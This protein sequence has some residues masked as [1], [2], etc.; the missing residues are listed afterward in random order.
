[1]ETAILQTQIQQPYRR[2]SWVALLQQIFDRVEIFQQPKSWPL[3]TQSEKKLARDLVQ[4]GRVT[5]TDGKLI[6]LFEVDVSKDVDLASNRVGLRKL[7]ARCIDEISAHSVLAFFI[8]PGG[9]QY[10]LSYAARESALDVETLKVETRETATRRFTY[11]L[12]PGV[13]IRTAA[14]RL[15]TLSEKR[16]VTELKHVTDAFSVERLND[17]FFAIYKKHYELF[18]DHLLVSNAPKRIFKIEL[19][20]LND[21][22]RDRALKP[23]RDFVKKLLGRLVF[24]YFLQKKGWLGCPREQTEWTKGNTNFIGE[25]FE[26]CANKNCFHTERLIPLFF[27]TLN[28][29]AR[30]N[31]IFSITGTR[32]PYLNGGLFERDFAA[33]SQIDF[34]A[35]RFADLLDFFSQYNFTIDENDPD[36]REIGIDPEMLGHIFENLLE[37]NKDKGAYYTPKPVVQYMCQHSLIHYLRAHFP[38]DSEAATEIERLI[39]D[40]DP[41]DPRDTRSWIPRNAPRID[42]LLDSVKICDPAIG[43]G[44][45]PM[46]LLQEI[47]WT[48]LT[49]HPG[50]DRAATKRAI[51]QHSIH[52]VDIDAGAV[53]IARLRC[54]LAL[55]VD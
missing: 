2:E 40:K 21:K 20:G 3:T 36:D 28:N 7:V 34:P 14:Q 48:K 12:G 1:M 15:G 8:P 50:A 18:R 31:D 25:L 55:I 10:R 47:Y 27:D 38:E 23:I 43:S 26:T 49:L 19:A 24:L 33:V 39:R 16:G 46:G 32:V 29:Q 22:A 42:E 44:A 41:I 6:G 53:E 45:F 5:L 37:D 13:P 52:G 51:I 30:P 17:E 11:V 35:K 4:F 54:W 9:D